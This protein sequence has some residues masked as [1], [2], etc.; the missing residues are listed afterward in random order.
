ML[1]LHYFIWLFFLNTPVGSFFAVG[2]MANFLVT[3]TGS[4][5]ICTSSQTISQLLGSVY[6]L[7][8]FGVS[9][10]GTNILCHRYLIEKARVMIR[11]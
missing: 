8:T 3:A 4:G 11:L 5:I 1:Y 6:I 9:I 10:I 2:V 7:M